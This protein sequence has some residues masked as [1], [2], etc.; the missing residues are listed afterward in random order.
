MRAIRY[1]FFIIGGFCIGGVI[2]AASVDDLPPDSGGG[3]V[4]FFA[5]IGAFLGALAAS[6]ANRKAKKKRQ[7]S[8]QTTHTDNRYY[9]N[10]RVINIVTTEKDAARVL[11][12]LQ[13]NDR[14]DAPDEPLQIEI[15]ELHRL[16]QR[17]PNR[18]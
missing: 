8:P 18:E 4:I 12:S 2:G 5:F 17:R 7:P 15:E 1:F 9:D 16:P 14:L 13:E 3:I 6:N 11:Q 10:R